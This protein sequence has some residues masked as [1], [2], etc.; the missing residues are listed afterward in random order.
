MADII[1]RVDSC[2]L[3]EKHWS[4]ILPGSHL[5]KSTPKRNCSSRPDT[6]LRQ[7]TLPGCFENMN[8]GITNWSLNWSRTNYTMYMH[9][10]VYS[11]C[12]SELRNSWR[13]FKHI[14]YE[15]RLYLGYFLSGA[16]LSALFAY[17]TTST[18]PVQSRRRVFPWSPACRGRGT[19]LLQPG[20]PRTYTAGINWNQ[21]QS[22]FI[23][24]KGVKINRN[25]KW[26]N[27]TSGHYWSSI[28]LV[29][30]LKAA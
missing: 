30:A 25:Q 5:M 2:T 4:A 8:P 29:T 19:P 11:V 10:F 17:L 26:I 9:N 12:L 23:C 14:W 20:S 16:A 15:F 18:L 1:L 6:T 27:V 7:F 13:D 21:V 22:K 28:H 24:A 3:S